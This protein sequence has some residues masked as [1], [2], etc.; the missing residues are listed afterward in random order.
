MVVQHPVRLVITNYPEGKSE[1]FEVENNPNR[2]ED[3]MRTITFSRELYIERDDFMETPVK[4]YF[5][6]FPEMRCGSNPRISCA[7]P[8]VKG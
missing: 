3:G 8:A 7:V 4:G 1:T 2:P 5:R 6:L